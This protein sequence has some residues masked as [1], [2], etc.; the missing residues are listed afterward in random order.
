MN[1]AFYLNNIKNVFYYK[2][3]NC[4]NLELTPT[5]IRFSV[6]IFHSLVPRIVQ[7]V[8]LVHEIMMDFQNIKPK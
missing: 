5:F 4:T 2:F 3:E 1:Q 8:G 7:G 6:T